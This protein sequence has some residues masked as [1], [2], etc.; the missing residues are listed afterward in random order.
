LEKV[1]YNG[2]KLSNWLDYI[3][4]KFADQNYF[5]ID[6]KADQEY[7]IV[8]SLT[9]KTQISFYGLDDT[10][11]ILSDCQYSNADC[12]GWSGETCAANPDKY[13]TFTQDNLNTI[14][15][16]LETPI[17]KGWISVDYYLGDSF[18]KSIT[19]ADKDK[20]KPPFTYFGSEFGCI[21]IILF[22]IFIVIN[23]L[24]NK[25]I[26]GTNKEIIIEPIVNPLNAHLTT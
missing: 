18:Y 16:I 7:I 23:R 5:R 3:H 9:N 1:V 17:Y 21:S 8:N 24:L 26:I 4:L 19:Y 12:K 6:A 2:Q 15:E 20:T 11:L 25:G 10:G 22:P 13:G 14:D